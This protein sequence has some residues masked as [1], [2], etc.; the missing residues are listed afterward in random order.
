MSGHLLVILIM[1]AYS[2]VEIIN[3]TCDFLTCNCRIAS[4][5]IPWYT[6]GFL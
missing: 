5:M 6:S 2:A 3:N 1:A 4:L